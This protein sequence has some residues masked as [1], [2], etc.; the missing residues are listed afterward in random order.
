MASKKE[1][2]KLEVKQRGKY[3]CKRTTQ[4]TLWTK[5]KELCELSNK[6]VPSV[7]EFS[8]LSIGQMEKM[9]ERITT[10]LNFVRSF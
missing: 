7:V 5:K 1:W 10:E 9:L 6:P 4:R 3:Q 8:F 2:T